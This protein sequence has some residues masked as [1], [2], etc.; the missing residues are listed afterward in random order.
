MFQGKIMNNKIVSRC[1]LAGI[2]AGLVFMQG[3]S[4]FE[5]KTDI[6][7][8]ATQTGELVAKVE[9]GLQTKQ[10]ALLIRYLDTERI[11]E[12]ELYESLWNEM[13]TALRYVV[14][15][16][17][18][19]IEIAEDPNAEGSTDALANNLDALYS[20][21]LGLPS[22]GPALADV[23][24][25]NIL[26]EARSAEKFQDAAKVVNR[27]IDPAVEALD[28][29]TFRIAGAIDSSYAVLLEDID[30]YHADSI[31][32][33]D[34]VAGRR[35]ATFRQLEL[36]D[37]AF[38][39]ND[40]DAW[41]QLRESDRQMQI[42]LQGMDSPTLSATDKAQAVLMKQLNTL[43]ALNASLQPDLE[44]YQAE[45]V[46]LRDVGQS[47]DSA[48]AVAQLSID[49]W[50]RGHKLFVDGKK[51][52]FALVTSILMNYAIEKGKRKIF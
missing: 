42:A 18:V 33:Q 10:A 29:L 17:I 50:D 47:I 1:L 37:K 40:K 38:L 13:I 30:Q 12:I 45:L 36:L 48:I 4:V 11:P 5:G 49:A 20:G 31:R 51:S 7:P 34:L 39:E 19:L 32:Y 6:E 35:N 44:L 23:D 24:I 26:K 22:L 3:C 46:E 43:D 21:L 9:F 16:S 2:S 41:N 27:A 52:G 8:I 28:A 15:Y 14:K 25:E